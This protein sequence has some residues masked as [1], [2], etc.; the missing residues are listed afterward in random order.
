MT[1]FVT[2]PS[3]PYFRDVT[4]VVSRGEPCPFVR[5][6]GCSPAAIASAV[7]TIDFIAALRPDSAITV[8]GTPENRNLVGGIVFAVPN[9]AYAVCSDEHTLFIDL[10]DP[11]H[12]V[13]DLEPVELAVALIEASGGLEPTATQFALISDDG[14]VRD[15]SQI[16]ELTAQADDD[17]ATVLQ[18]AQAFARA[19]PPTPIGLSLPRLALTTL[20]DVPAGLIVDYGIITHAITAVGVVAVPASS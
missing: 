20:E 13:Y 6:V 7:E 14:D 11:H 18:H 9:R 17:V 3:T 16:H 8:T 19:L 12:P 2:V 5:A 1:Q 15:L 10:A 4:A